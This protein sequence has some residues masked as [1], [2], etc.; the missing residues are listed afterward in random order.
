MQ[1][2]ITDRVKQALLRGATANDGDDTNPIIKEGGECFVRF[3]SM[4]IE[5]DT[6]RFDP[7]VNVVF[8]W[9]GVDVTILSVNGPKLEP[10]VS[11]F[12]TG[13]EGRQAIS[14]Y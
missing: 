14:V 12:I 1:A 11:L 2:K 5:N 3:D 6:K 10:D 7:G 13:V 9:R 8:R 4:R